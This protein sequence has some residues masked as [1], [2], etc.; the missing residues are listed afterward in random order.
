MEEIEPNAW[1]DKVYNPEI[2][3]KPA[4]IYKKPGY[5]CTSRIFIISLRQCILR[6]AWMLNC[7]ESIQALDP[8][9]QR[10]WVSVNGCAEHDIGRAQT[11]GCPLCAKSRHAQMA[12]SQSEACFLIV[13]SLI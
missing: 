3:G 5:I 9:A 13:F 2:L 10:Y 1:M 8:M 4:Q 12:S 11:T 7:A 6:V